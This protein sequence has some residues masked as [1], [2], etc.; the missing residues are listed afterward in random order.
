MI[1]RFQSKAA[2]DVVMLGSVGD[3]VLNAMGIPPA[4]KGIIEPRAMPAAI[5]AVEAAIA[6]DEALRSAGRSPDTDV[7][8]PDGG[9][10]FVS[11]RQRAWPLVEMM[12]RSLDAGEAIVWGV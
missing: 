5:G 2:G 7:R 11:L 4:A 3:S 6:S 1:Y 8:E 9:A 12:R 10:E